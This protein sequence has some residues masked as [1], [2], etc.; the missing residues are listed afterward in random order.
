MMG[1]M[2]EDIRDGL[3]EASVHLVNKEYDLLAGDFVTLGLVPP[4]SEMGEFTQALTGVFQEAVAKGVRNIS[5][6]DLSEKLGVTMYKFKFRIPSYFSLVIRS[7]TVL[8]GIALSSDP[9]Y[10][11][12]S[13][14]YPWIAR[15][16]LTDKSPKLRSTLQELVYKDGG[17]RIDRLES[18]LTESMRQPLED[19]AVV[20]N[21]PAEKGRVKAENDNR[22]LVKRLLTFGLTDQGD[23]VRE[24]ILDELAKGID[25]LNRVAFDS[26][27]Q[28]IRMRS[29]I[30]LPITTPITED[31]DLKNLENLRK[32][33]SIFN[34]DY[35]R[36]GVGTMA[37]MGALG[38]DE[39]Q[40][41][42]TTQVTTNN[43]RQ[44]STNNGRQM[45]T[46]NGRQMSTSN[47][48]QMSTSNGRQM[49]TSIG[50]QMSTNGNGSV[51]MEQLG[52][53]GA[54]TVSN[55]NDVV[56]RVAV[57]NET[58]NA[59]RVAK[60][61]V[62]E[63]EGDNEL[64]ERTE[65]VKPKQ[66]NGNGNGNGSLTINSQQLQLP[67]PRAV[68]GNGSGIG[69]GN[70]RG[71]AN[72]NGR[73]PVTEV[74]QGANK[75]D[76][77]ERTKFVD[78]ENAGRDLSMTDVSDIVQGLS[79]LTQYLPLLSVVTELPFQA[80]QQAILLPAELAGRV[81][82]RVAARTIRRSIPKSNGRYS[83]KNTDDYY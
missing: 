7:L 55:G 10:K 50:R 49:S 64:V 58:T 44:M 37:S 34:N 22:S 17:F 51:Q 4:T 66:S 32:I 74:V 19:P 1:E 71:Y 40:T 30:S 43:G 25:A 53:N 65:F 36:S 38:D 52:Y 24:L 29:P 23:F 14:S 39:T 18:L 20:A 6:G 5:F 63:G 13:S 46:S 78:D 33:M 9:N 81:V 83:S 12:L 79:G 73:V 57:L 61:E 62:I 59:E 42:T 28:Q 70:G 75:N 26:A 15:K 69:N 27:A 45:S 68:N 11:V 67:S 16:V 82:S 47:G 54:V 56:Q 48:R 2:K 41:S 35:S 76:L 31:E 77:V 72:G 80:R 3:I 60:T 21:R 8:E